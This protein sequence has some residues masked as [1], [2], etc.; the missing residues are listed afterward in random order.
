MKIWG[1]IYIGS[2][3]LL[4]G[5]MSLRRLEVIAFYITNILEFVFLSNNNANGTLCLLSYLLPVLRVLPLA[6]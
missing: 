1:C 3:S 6:S 5:W 4:G 2:P